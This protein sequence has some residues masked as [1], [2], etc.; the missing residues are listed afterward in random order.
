MTNGKAALIFIGCYIVAMLMACPSPS[1]ILF[2]WMFPLGLFAVIGQGGMSNKTLIVIGYLPYIL[3]L[4]LMLR[5]HKKKIFFK[6]I[7]F[8]LLGLLLLNVNGC[9]GMLKGLN[10]IT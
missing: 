1:G 6:I 10:R 8:I 7:L 2:F 3:M 5:F 9:W 4:A